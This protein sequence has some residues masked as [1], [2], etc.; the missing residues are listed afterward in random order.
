MRKVLGS[1]A[2]MAQSR[3]SC[4]ARLDRLHKQVKKFDSVRLEHNQNACASKD[5]F[6]L[7]LFCVLVCS[8]LLVR[9]NGTRFSLQLINLE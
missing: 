4:N 2:I 1:G 8:H 5:S 9:E 3:L 6:S 7:L